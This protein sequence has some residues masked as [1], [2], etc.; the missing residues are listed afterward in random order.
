MAAAHDTKL[1]SRRIPGAIGLAL[2]TTLIGPALAAATVTNVAGSATKSEEWGSAGPGYTALNQ[3]KAG[4]SGSN[5]LLIPDGGATIKVNPDGT[6]ADWPTLEMANTY[7]GDVLLFSQWRRSG[8]GDIKLYDLGSGT[9]VDAPAGVNTSAS[10]NRPSLSG[11]HLLFGRGPANEPS[12]RAILYDLASGTSK[13]IAKADYIWVGP[14][15][16]DWVVYQAC[17]RSCA[18]YRY[19]TSTGERTT[20]PVP[21]RKWNYFPIID[22]DG[23]VYYGSS[24]FD[25]GLGVRL[26]RHVPGAQSSTVVQR[27]PARIDI[28]PSDVVDHAIYFGRYDCNRELGDIYRLTL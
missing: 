6:N 26:M 24:G 25:C 28:F 22:D 8:Q 23:T 7:L 12:T 21:P 15:N 5:V 2:L 27:F 1:R 16:G 11:A 20:V 10:E 13:V 18:I 9:F 4:S 14:V 3:R 19:Q 17:N